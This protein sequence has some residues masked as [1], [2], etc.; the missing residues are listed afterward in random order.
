MI[1]PNFRTEVATRRKSGPLENLEPAPLPEFENLILQKLEG[2]AAIVNTAHSYTQKAAL[3]ILEDIID[4]PEEHY[5]LLQDMVDNGHPDDGGVAF[6]KGLSTIICTGKKSQSKCLLVRKFQLSANW[7]DFVLDSQIIHGF[8]NLS[9]VMQMN[10]SSL[11][12]SFRQQVLGRMPMLFAKILEM[13]E[14]HLEEIEN[15]LNYRS[16]RPNE[17]GMSQ[18]VRQL[19]ASSKDEYDEDESYFVSS[20]EANDDE[21]ADPTF[22]MYEYPIE[23]TPKN[24]NAETRHKF[25]AVIKFYRLNNL[26]EKSDRFVVVPSSPIAH[27]SVTITEATLLKNLPSDTIIFGEKLKEWFNT[28]NS[29]LKKTQGQLWSQLFGRIVDKQKL[30]LVDA[31][32]EVDDVVHKKILST[33]IRTNGFDLELLYVDRRT[34]AEKTKKP[35]SN[36]L[37]DQSKTYSSRK[38]LKSDIITTEDKEKIKT[39]VGGDPGEVYYVGLCATKV[40]DYELDPINLGELIFKEDAK[41][42]NLKLKTTAAAEPS[43]RYR[44]WLEHQ[45]TEEIFSQE[46]LLGRT[47]K[48]MENRHVVQTT[49]RLQRAVSGVGWFRGDEGTPQSSQELQISQESFISHDSNQPTVPTQNRHA[50]QR[51][52]RSVSGGWARGGEGT[53]QSSQEMKFSQE[54]VFSHDSTVPTFRIVEEPVLEWFARW[55]QSYQVLSVF[56]NSRKMK[57]RRFDLMRALRHELDL[58]VNATLKTGGGSMATKSDGSILFAF[59]D[60][61]MS[62]SGR[63]KIKSYSSSYRYLVTKLRSLG[64]KVVFYP[65][66]WTSQRFP[67]TGQKMKGS[68]SNEVRIY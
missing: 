14:P 21:E 32:K 68:G 10:A 22:L 35:S 60:C 37:A 23:E 50:V 45:K 59:G 8:K 38:K 29:T 12:A 2:M 44:N 39:V 33:T 3:F 28:G 7:K 18:Y 19:E 48:R 47:V 13:A 52:Q 51:L 43:R 63:K 30:K 57:K 25:D 56:Y 55:K 34:V 41:V 27:K 61:L 4:G 11:A 54:S 64:H 1:K 40:A 31:V 53:P 9:A 15:I 6:W 20:Q 24:W 62:D 42:T 26:L 36:S 46:R 66:H 17:E 49:A 16:P 67:M 58:G 5:W 65:E